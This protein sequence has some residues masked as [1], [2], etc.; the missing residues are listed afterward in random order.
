MGI[1]LP[2][3]RVMIT[4]SL[5]SLPVQMVTRPAYCLQSML[6]TNNT[7]AKCGAGMNGLTTILE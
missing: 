1:V 4:L 6:T 5:N 3:G 2:G 7:S